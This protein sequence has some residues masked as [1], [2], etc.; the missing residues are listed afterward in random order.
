MALLGQDV[1]AT[2]KL[3]LAKETRSYAELA[4]SLGI[5]PSQAYQSVQRAMEAGLLHKNDRQVHRAALI[6]FLVHGL[7][8]VF[9]ARRGPQ[10][11]GIPTAHAAKPLSE[12]IDASES[13]WVW[14]SA[15]GSVRGES[16]EPLHKCAATAIKNDEP[17]YEVL[18]LI[19]ALRA[20]KA[21]ERK[22]AIKHLEDRLSHA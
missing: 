15:E 3:A 5:S 8:Y 19:D 14:P 16:L 1:V 9:P 4:H 7:K 22:L 12:I 13:M 10:T 18:A 21:R 6:E 17:L 2:L 20:G 11:R